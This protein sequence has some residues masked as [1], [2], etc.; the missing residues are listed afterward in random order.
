MC[1][2]R[3]GCCVGQEWGELVRGQAVENTMT[4]NSALT[5]VFIFSYIFGSLI[6]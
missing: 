5:S 2:L 4:F 3:F 6:A 1:V